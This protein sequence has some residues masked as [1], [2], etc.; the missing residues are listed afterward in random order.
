VG[1]NKMAYYR[2]FYHIIW[3]TKNREPII[4]DKWEQDLY[5]YIWG[6]STALECLPHA[7][8]GMPNHIHL[9]ISVPPKLSISNIVGQLKGSSSR[10]INQILQPEVHFAW[11]SSYGVLSVSERNRSKLIYYV[12]NQKRHHMAGT[13]NRNYEIIDSP[14]AEPQG[15]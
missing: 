5:G 14:E 13:I 10:Y 11:Q 12:N 3:A 1:E 15:L 6:K 9:F 2:L 8:N 7:I 4:S